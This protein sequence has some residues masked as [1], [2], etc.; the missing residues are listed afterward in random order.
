MT[1]IQ[2][3][4]TE[5]HP[6]TVPMYTIWDVS[7]YLRISP[8]LTADMCGHGHLES[9]LLIRRHRHWGLFP[10]VEDGMLSLGNERNQCIPFVQLADCF[11]WS[12]LAHAI[13]TYQHSN[14]FHN[15][16]HEQSWRS[17]ARFN[18]KSVFAGNG[19]AGLEKLLAPFPGEL[20]TTVQ[21]YY[22]RVELNGGVP[23]RLFPFSRE[24]NAEAPQAIVIDPNISFGKPTLVGS[25]VP[26]NALYE[27]FQ[28]GDSSQELADDY[29]LDIAEVDE[30]IRFESRLPFPMFAW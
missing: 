2:D 4:L 5:Q 18:F 20:Q 30:A 19:L 10:L 3:R 7:R 15:R 24:P 9:E 27:R 14:G 22:D 21:L 1:A 11:V 25:G 17:I 29:G 6:S 13:S 28:A 12:S 8:W 26:T 23:I 16:H